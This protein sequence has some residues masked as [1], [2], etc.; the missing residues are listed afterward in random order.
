MCS[1]LEARWQESRDA[2]PLWMQAQA[3]QL[4]TDPAERLAAI[5]RMEASLPE[6][7]RTMKRR[8]FSQAGSVA[9]VPAVGMLQKDGD[10]YSR[11]STYYSSTREITSA[12][13]D[14]ASTKGVR[15]ILLYTDSPGG[16]VDG[17][18]EAANAI[19]DLVASGFPVVAYASGMMASGAYWLGS[20]A[21]A[22]Y[23]DPTADIGSIGVRL[24]LMNLSAYFA[25]KGITVETFTTGTYKDAC[26]PYRPMTDADRAYFQKSVDSTLQDF[27]A[28]VAKGRKKMSADML[29]RVTSEAAVYSPREAL[30]LGLIDGI[31]SIQKVLTDLNEATKLR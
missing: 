13:W 25:D 14:A 19:S 20:Q 18:A 27:A 23:S 11:Y 4:L 22:V 28:G 6:E 17:T 3:A 1:S 9:I 2:D 10:W 7:V 29:A 15:S 21:S 30:A 26:N 12:L 16:Y 5:H 24:S 31:A 8:G